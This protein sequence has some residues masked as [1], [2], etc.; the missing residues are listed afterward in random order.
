M[1][2]KIIEKAGRTQMRAALRDV[3]RTSFLRRLTELRSVLT[4]GSLER[5]YS[6]V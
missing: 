2:N 6:A 1:T 4:S 5:R 3:A